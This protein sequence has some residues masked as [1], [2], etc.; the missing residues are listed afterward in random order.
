MSEIGSELNPMGEFFSLHLLIESTWPFID[1]TLLF[2]I[3]DRPKEVGDFALSEY[4]EK[5]IIIM[6]DCDFDFQL[7]SSIK[8][9]VTRETVKIT[10]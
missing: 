1:Y 3:K 10:N 9:V 5:C 4:N 6:F 8:T 2:M 7:S